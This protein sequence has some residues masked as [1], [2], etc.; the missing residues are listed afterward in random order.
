MT[1]FVVAFLVI[2]ALVLLLWLFVRPLDDEL[3]HLSGRSV[4]PHLP[5][6]QKIGPDASMTKADADASG[7]SL[8][9]AEERQRRAGEG[10]GSSLGS[11]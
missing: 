11:G 8:A 9:A 4:T 2:A 10:I 1:L 3:R 5:S 6:A 7:S